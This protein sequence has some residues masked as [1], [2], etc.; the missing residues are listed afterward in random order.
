MRVLPREAI[1][2]KFSSIASQYRSFWASSRRAHSS[3]EKYTA[4]SSKVMLPCHDE[5]RGNH[6]QPLGQGSPI[7]IPPYVFMLILLPSS[8]TQ[9]R[10]QTLVPFVSV[11]S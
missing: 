9:I 6:E 8:T 5:E 11:P 1:S 3:K 7:Q 10:Y 4:T 2:A